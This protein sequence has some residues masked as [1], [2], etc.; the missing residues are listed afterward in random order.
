MTKGAQLKWNRTEYG[1]SQKKLAD[2][3]GVSQYTIHRLENDTTAWLTVRP[4]TED[5]L[6]SALER[7]ASE[8]K[9]EVA[10]AY[11]ELTGE[12]K[13][14]PKV[15][16]KEEKKSVWPTES[17]TYEQAVE[18]ISKLPKKDEKTLTLLTTIWKWLNESKTHEEFAENIN[19]M[20]CIIDQY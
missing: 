20:K 19:M 9:E 13:V 12:L 4:T 8:Q 5:K 18:M 7:F 11:K 16:E 15:V 2:L 6:W 3:A 1:L 14:E 17:I 10:K